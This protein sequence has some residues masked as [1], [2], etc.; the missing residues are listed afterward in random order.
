MTHKDQFSIDRRHLLGG[1]AA[2]AAALALRPGKSVF[3][4]PA[5]T[6]DLLKA[7]FQE[8]DNVII[9]GTLGEAQSINPFLT[10]ESEGDWR[11][12]MIF[13]AFVRMDPATIQP[14]PGPGLAADWTIDGLSYT[15]SIHE[16][17]TFSDGT[18]VTADDVAFAIHGHLA[19][20]TASPRQTRFLSIAGAQEY[21][22][23]SAESVSGV[24]VIDA[25]TIKITLAV[26]DA[27]F[28]ISLMDLYVP[29]KAA[30]EGKS[31]VDDPW[32]L[33]P[34][35]AGP[36]VFESWSNGGDF[37]ARKNEHY[38][39]EGKPG[40][41]GFIHRVIADSTSL[42]L[43]LQSNE[44]EGSVYPAPTLKEQLEE[45]PDLEILT[46]PFNSPNGWMFNCTNE[47][48]A[49]KEVRQAIAKAIPVEQYAADSLLGLGRAGVGPIAPDSWAF[50]TELQ[51]LAYDPAAAKALLDSVGFP[52]GTEIR[53]NVNQGNVLREDWLVLTQ[54]ALAEI[55]ITVVPEVIEY[56]TLV[57]ATT[58]NRDYDVSGVDF[59]GATVDP[60]QLYEQFRSD[61]SGNYMGYS[62]PELDEL[63]V[64]AKQELDPEVAKDLYKQIQAIIVDD[65]PFF[66]AWYRPFLHAVHK[67]YTGWT[68]SNLT[69][70]VFNTLEDFVLA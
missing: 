63:L 62:N 19:T 23:G 6:S 37:V 29:P 12:K 17:A 30:L 40:L 55:G 51:P 54:Q 46:P 65:S 27:S 25:K 70:G 11:C 32:F 31:L 39:Q 21:A 7:G 14:V 45:N 38:Y 3:G 8:G 4:A 59:A 43:A 15:F 20:S 33:N 13:E 10:N 22:D 18:D 53:F 49:K 47:W 61:A 48:L 28:V 68:G 9:I 50:D 34:V 64:Q 58:V 56:T 66:F 16:N 42:V 24:E 2:T 67:K 5:G 1:A 60:G 69:Q 57:E 52:E 26:P 35:G 36:F 41:D 44:I